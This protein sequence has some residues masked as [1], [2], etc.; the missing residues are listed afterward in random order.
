MKIVALY[1]THI[2]FNIK[3]DPIFDF[4]V[5]FKPDTII[6]GGDMHD[7]TAASH[8]IADQGS[9]LDGQSI[10]KCYNELKD[11]LLDPLRGAKPSH[12][13][14]VYLL[15]NHEDWLQQ[16][17][18]LNRNGRDYWEMENNIDLKGY[19]MELIPVNNPFVVNDHLCYIHGVYT[20]EYHAKKTVQA[21]HTSIFYGHVHDVQVYTQVSPISIDHFYKGAS[22]GCLCNLNPSYM[23]NKPNRWVHGFH[24]CYVN[25][26]TGAFHDTQVFIVKGAFWANGRYY[27]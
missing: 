3:L 4:I 21:Y 9:A 8:W 15:G 16:T 2:P 14:M 10:K 7:W 25:D 12:S 6:L 1:D 19:R 22:V 11:I 27:K 13:R 20:N 5:D 18:N 26:K 24:F 23:R 17:I